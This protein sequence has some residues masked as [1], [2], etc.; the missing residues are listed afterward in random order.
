VP[1]AAVRA[2]A[3]QSTGLHYYDE[4]PAEPE[5]AGDPETD[6]GFRRDGGSALGDGNAER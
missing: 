1:V 6:P 3:A 5:H 2:A 4:A